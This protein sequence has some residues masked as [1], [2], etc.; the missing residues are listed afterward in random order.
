MAPLAGTGLLTRPRT[1]TVRQKQVESASGPLVLA[2]DTTHE[3]GSLA[4]VRGTETVEEV[5]LHAPTG[6]AHVLYPQLSRLLD[7]HGIALGS[8]DCFAAA[9]GPGSFTGVRVGLACVKGLAEAL[10]KPAF[11]VSNL[12]A[13]ASFA[14]GGLRAA[15]I[16]A[17]R[18]DI[19]GGLYDWRLRPAAPEMVA[20]FPVWLETLP[21]EDVVF[22]SSDFT[23]F[24]SALAG[25]R[26]EKFLVVTA[27]PALAGAIGSLAMAHFRAGERPD[28]ASLDANYVRRSDAE[29]FW[30][31]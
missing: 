6:F 1:R 13:L 22:V 24:H 29:L 2:I 18:G 10:G 9:A 23:P 21:A 12:Q 26:F 3:F 31:E 28:P 16:D 4:L 8:I 20:K 30:K 11:A 15:V 7:R 25:T 5:L 19:Y 17:R 27:E 14:F